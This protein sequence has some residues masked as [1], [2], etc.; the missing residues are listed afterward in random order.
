MI[1]GLGSATDLASDKKGA[2]YY[3]LEEFHKYWD[4]IDIVAP[5]VRGISAGEKVF[6]GNVH[7]YVSGLPLFLHPF[8]FVWKCLRINK[9]QKFKF[10]TVQEFPPFYNG[11]AARI[12][13]F[14]SGLPYVVEI[15][16]IPGLP[17]AANIKE[18]V[19]KWLARVFIAFDTRSARAVRV[20]NQ[21]QTKEFLIKSGV[22]ENKVV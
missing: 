15:M 7:L 19:Y 4:R 12:I 18:S 5:R 11:I 16:H 6:F 8:Y 2:F 21:K 20:I 14:L 22:S 10:M 3:T 9:A 17:R 13:H 1:T